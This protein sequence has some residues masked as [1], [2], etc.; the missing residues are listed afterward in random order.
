MGG[1][2]SPSV[3]IAGDG[4]YIGI[5]TMD[6][7]ISELPYRME[8]YTEFNLATWLRSIKYTVL[9]NFGFRISNI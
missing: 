2:S 6:N 1:Y 4:V 8:N 5:L 9:A 7:D 3:S